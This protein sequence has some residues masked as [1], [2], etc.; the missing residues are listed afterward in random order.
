MI[1]TLFNDFYTA[2]Y[3]DLNTDFFIISKPLYEINYTP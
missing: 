3:N 1:D 2:L